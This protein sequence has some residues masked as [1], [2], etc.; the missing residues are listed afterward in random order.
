MEAEPGELGVEAVVVAVEVVSETEEQGE[1]AELNMEDAAQSSADEAAG[2]EASS[3][4][5]PDP[6][7]SQQMA[8]FE[9]ALS[10]QAQAQQHAPL[11]QQ[12]QQVQQLAEPYLTFIIL[13]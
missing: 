8:T 5:S 11:Q 2:G 3:L 10:R 7:T 13:K 4:L 1:E 6:M 12:M 9:A